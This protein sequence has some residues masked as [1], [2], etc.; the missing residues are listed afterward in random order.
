L[1]VRRRQHRQPKPHRRREV[2]LRKRLRLDL[3]LVHVGRPEKS[4][5]GVRGRIPDER[6]LATEGVHHDDGQQRRRHLLAE[7]VLKGLIVYRYG[8]DAL[9]L[10]AV[11]AHPS[12]GS[13]RAG[14]SGL[15]PP[16]VL[17]L[18]KHER[19]PPVRV[20]IRRNLSLLSYCRV[21]FSLLPRAVLPPQCLSFTSGPNPRR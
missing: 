21:L 6:E 5:P 4:G 10:L 15:A 16:F 19:V 1:R 17:S 2:P 12:T 20:K 13:G 18:S 7:A 3:A 14:N 8:T 11:P 9:C